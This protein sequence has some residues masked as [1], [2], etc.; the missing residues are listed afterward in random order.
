VGGCDHATTHAHPDAVAA[1]RLFGAVMSL[2][3]NRAAG[4][5][6]I[7]SAGSSCLPEGVP[8]VF[9]LS[10]VPFPS[11]EGRQAYTAST[12]LQR[13]CEWENCMDFPCAF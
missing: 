6:L 5:L 12:T 7:A 10:P 3:L 8:D 1:S 11:V 9:Q 13:H 2:A 4:L